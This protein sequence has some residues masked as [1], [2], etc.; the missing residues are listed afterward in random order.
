MGIVRGKR[1]E[2]GHRDPLGLQHMVALGRELISILVGLV[3]G[4]GV[5][6]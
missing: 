5:G 3:F 4:Q 2:V 6:V 1:L